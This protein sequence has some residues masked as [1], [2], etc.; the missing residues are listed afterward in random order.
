MDRYIIRYFV[1]TLLWSL[2]S[3][4]GSKYERIG[5]YVD[6]IA[7]A[8]NSNREYSFIDKK[9]KLVNRWASFQY[10]D[11]FSEGYAVVQLKNDKYAFVDRKIKK[12][13]E[14]YSKLFSFK[15]GHALFSDRD[16]LGVLD[17]SFS[18]VL[19]PTYD[20]IRDFE[21]GYAV[22]ELGGK[23][24]YINTD[25]QLVIPCDYQ[26]A[27]DFSDGCAI[28]NGNAFVDK[29]GKLTVVS[30]C[31]QLSSFNNGYAVARRGSTS[32]SY[33]FQRGVINK[34]GRFVIPFGNYDSISGPQEGLFLIKHW[35]G[36]YFYLDEN[37]N[38]PFQKSFDS[39]TL[40]SNGV[41]KVTYDDKEFELRIDNTLKYKTSAQN[42]VKEM[43]IQGRWKHRDDVY[44]VYTI[45]I[46]GTSFELWYPSKMI[47]YGSIERSGNTLKLNSTDG[48]IYSVYINSNRRALEWDNKVFYRE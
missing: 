5:D 18:V 45:K 25:Y 16:R 7:L 24:G 37:G 30:Q 35:Y 47:G 14:E 13:S 19:P 22:V 32:L 36:D 43:S 9:G 23:Y 42:N 11:S 17:K 48:N 44:G 46:E 3:C 28:V 33:P 38:D 10:A 29:N 4:S 31:E 12:V 26:S 40:F 6:G 15:N 41:A 34:K 39:A 21:E 27:F 1:I 20:D 2:L 8:Q